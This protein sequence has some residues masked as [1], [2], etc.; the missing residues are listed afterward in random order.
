MV[1]KSSMKSMRAKGKGKGTPMKSMKSM[2][3]N[4]KGKGK[5]DMPTQIAEAVVASSITSKG[6]GKD[7]GSG[8]MPMPTQEAVRQS[9]LSAVPCTPQG[10]PQ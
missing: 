10:L 7:K 1:M 9:T 2:K 3:A 5:G 6:K 4:G 8:K